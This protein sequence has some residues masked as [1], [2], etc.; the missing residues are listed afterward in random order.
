MI[1]NEHVSAWIAS[2]YFLPTDPTLKWI[3]WELF[4]DVPSILLFTRVASITEYCPDRSLDKIIVILIVKPRLSLNHIALGPLQ[5]R[6][7]A[8]K[9]WASWGWFKLVIRPGCYS[10][11]FF[12]FLKHSFLTSPGKACKTGNCAFNCV[13]RMS[14]LQFVGSRI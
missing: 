6:L 2:M 11:S 13:V 3:S 14:C 7:L 9:G 8:A 1:P 4:Y 10:L 5:F 12:E